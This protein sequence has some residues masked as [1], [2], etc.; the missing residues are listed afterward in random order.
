MKCTYSQLRIK[1]TAL[2]FPAVGCFYGIL[3]SYNNLIDGTGIG[4]VGKHA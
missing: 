3:L 4:T 2:I 1:P